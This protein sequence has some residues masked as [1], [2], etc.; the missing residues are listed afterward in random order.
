[1]RSD[2]ARC[3]KS[4]NSNTWREPK[5]YQEE[6]DL[7]GIAQIR[8][9][10]ISMRSIRPRPVRTHAILIL[11][12]VILP[13]Q[14]LRIHETA[15][16]RA[17]IVRVRARVT[18]YTYCTCRIELTASQLSRRDFPTASDTETVRSLESRER[19]QASC[20]ITLRTPRYFASGVFQSLTWRKILRAFVRSRQTE[21]FSRTVTYMNQWRNNGGRIVKMFTSSMYDVPITRVGHI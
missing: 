2:K 20:D 21:G 1:M 9:G 15:V 7:A 13:R 18:Y 14:F 12:R 16:A 11:Y 3:A 10:S 8:V 19:D 17:K 4:A 6:G 5:N